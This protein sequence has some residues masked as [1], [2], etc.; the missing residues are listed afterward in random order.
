MSAEPNSKTLVVNVPLGKQM[1]TV[2]AW[3]TDKTKIT[4]G[5]KLVSFGSLKQ[6]ARVRIVFHRVLSPDYSR[7]SRE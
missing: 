6:G 7:K 2:N 1:L 5:G 4:A 3:A